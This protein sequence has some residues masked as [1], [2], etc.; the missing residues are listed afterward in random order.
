[1]VKPFKF[2]VGNEEDEDYSIEALDIETLDDDSASWT[3]T[4][5][6]PLDGHVY[7]IIET[8]SEGIHE[9][10]SRFPN[11]FCVPVLSIVGPNGRFHDANTNYDDGWGFDITSS[12]LVIRFLRFIP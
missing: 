9:F 2:F 6:L 11:R 5:M 1:M 8:R 12:V 7:D 10:L 3:W 4:S